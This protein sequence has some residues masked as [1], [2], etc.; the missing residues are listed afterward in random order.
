MVICLRFRGTVT[1]SQNYTMPLEDGNADDVLVT[2]GNGHV[3][4]K[5]N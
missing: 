2:D 4:W 1:I 5:T 3:F